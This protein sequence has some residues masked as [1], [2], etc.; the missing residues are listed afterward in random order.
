MYKQV[1][2]SGFKRKIRS[3]HILLSLLL[4]QIQWFKNDL[5]YTPLNNHIQS[6][7]RIDN[8]SLVTNSLSKLDSGRY[9]CSA[10]NAGEFQ[11]TLI[12][13]DNSVFQS[14]LKLLQLHLLAVG[15]SDSE[16]VTIDVLR[17]FF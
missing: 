5:L 3:I 7:L 11:F 4:Q 8:T 12:D 2:E 15:T 17:K 10:R 14:K 16:S 6:E 9:A 1:S 13:F